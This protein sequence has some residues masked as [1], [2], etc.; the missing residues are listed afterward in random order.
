MRTRASF[1]D[2]IELHKLTIFST[3]ATETQRYYMQQSVKKPQRILV[4]QYMARLGLLN[5]YIA[6]L[7]SVKDSPAA[8]QDTKKGNVLFDE[9]DLA[10]IILKSVPP[11]WL[12][13][14]N[15]THTTLPPQGSCFCT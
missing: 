9:A 15:L 1:L 10:D 14:Y 8:V 4:R 6:H 5:D 11:T 12:N 7:P 3:D 13:Q 2:Y